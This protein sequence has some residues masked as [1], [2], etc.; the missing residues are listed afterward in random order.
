MPEQ[1]LLPSPHHDI[2]RGENP[3]PAPIACRCDNPGDQGGHGCLS[4]AHIVRKQ[5]AAARRSANTSVEPRQNISRREKLAAS[6]FE[7]QLRT[8]VYISIRLG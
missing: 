2:V 4:Q 7:V 1:L 8:G 5:D 6:A 3:Y